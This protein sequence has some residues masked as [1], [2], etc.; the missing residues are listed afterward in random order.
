MPV[1]VPVV[2]ETVEAVPA[3]LEDAT[4]GLVRAGRAGPL[5]AGPRLRLRYDLG[6]LRARTHRL[7]LSAQDYEVAVRFATED[8]EGQ[9]RRR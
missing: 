7:D 2:I 8:A 3:C 9:P 4:R 5:C 6:W 1:P